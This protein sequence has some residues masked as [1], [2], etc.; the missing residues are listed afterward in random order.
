MVKEMKNIV[1]NL[2]QSVKQT[3]LKNGNDYLIQLEKVAGEK[4]KD[5]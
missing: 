1:E 5:P 4:W 3:R 2:M